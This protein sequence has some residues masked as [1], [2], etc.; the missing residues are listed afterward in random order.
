[1]ALHVAEHGVVQYQNI[2]TTSYQWVSIR[3]GLVALVALVA[4]GWIYPADMNDRAVAGA[5]PVST[6]G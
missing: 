5:Y 1:M 6:L 3:G 4:A 2:P